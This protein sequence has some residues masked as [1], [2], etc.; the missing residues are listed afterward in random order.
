MVENKED[1]HVVCAGGMSM[2]WSGFL[3]GW[4]VAGAYAV[5]KTITK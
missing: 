4:G 5:T 3:P 2:R 1:I